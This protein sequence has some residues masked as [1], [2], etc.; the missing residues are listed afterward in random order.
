MRGTRAVLL[1]LLC[2]VRARLVTEIVPWGAAEADSFARLELC[3]V[4]CMH[5]AL[6]LLLLLVSRMRRETKRARSA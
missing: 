3:G 5:I 6:L 2:A 1:L 4:R